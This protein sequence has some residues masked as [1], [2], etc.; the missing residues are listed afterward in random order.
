MHTCFRSKLK[1][2]IEFD[3]QGREVIRYL[4]HQIEEAIMYISVCIT[5]TSIYEV[6]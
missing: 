5:V 1:E 3:D 6:T 2:A 4:A